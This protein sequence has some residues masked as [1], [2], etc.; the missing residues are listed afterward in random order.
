MTLKEP[1]HHLR[2]DVAGRDRIDANAMDAPLG[3]Q[4]PAELL[5]GGLR[6]IVGRAQQAAVRD[7][8]GHAGDEG[9]GA[10]RD[11]VRDHGLGDGL[12]GHHDAG[13]VDAEQAV[14]VLGG[15]VEG[16]RL[17][18]DTGCGDEAV[19]AVVGVGDGCDDGVQAG[20]VGDV[21]VLEGEGGA[22]G[23]GFLLDAGEVLRGLLKAVECVDCEVLVSL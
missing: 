9:D 5:H 21:D 12:G 15:E 18:L 13:D 22:E 14:A 19:D 4:V 7:R 16:R 23:L 17:L 6:R 20:D 10:V 3:A 2:L 11:A 1:L 8:A